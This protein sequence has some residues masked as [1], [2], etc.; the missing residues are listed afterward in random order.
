MCWFYR[1][2]MYHQQNNWW[3]TQPTSI[4]HHSTHD[5]MLYYNDKWKIPRQD[6]FLGYF[7]TGTNPIRFQIP[8]GCSIEKNQGYHQTSCAYRGSL[9]WNSRITIDQ[10][11]VLSTDRPYK[12]FKKINRVSNNRVKNQWKRVKC[13]NRTQ[14]LKHFCPIEIF[15]YFW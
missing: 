12:I 10:T 7:F 4:H 2:I 15:T 6:D 14:L 11:I 13:I 9:R 3:Y 5:A 8:L 1:I